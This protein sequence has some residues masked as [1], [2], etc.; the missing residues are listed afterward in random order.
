MSGA[1]SHCEFGVL[2]C[3]APCIRILFCPINLYMHFQ[4]S[5]DDIKVERVYYSVKALC[6]VV[7]LFDPIDPCLG[8][9]YSA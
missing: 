6:G 3:A 9:R 2:V 1:F 4:E 7:S 8:G 5:G